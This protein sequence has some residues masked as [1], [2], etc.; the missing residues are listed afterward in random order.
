MQLY[1]KLN[2]NKIHTI[3]VCISKSFYKSEKHFNHTKPQ[4][5]QVGTA[6]NKNIKNLILAIV[7]L[8]V[9][10]VIIGK[11]TKFYIDLMYANNISFRILDY[12]L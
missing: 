9:N 1:F 8:N 12:I 4:I 11:L 5:L 6:S 2:N 7:G 3:P 10:L